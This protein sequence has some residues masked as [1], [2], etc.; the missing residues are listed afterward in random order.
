MTALHNFFTVIPDAPESGQ[1]LGGGSKHRSLAIIVILPWVLLAL[2]AATLDGSDTVVADDQSYAGRNIAQQ[3]AGPVIP[4]DIRDLL[5]EA[6]RLGPAAL[7]QPAAG[8][9]IDPKTG[10][11]TQLRRARD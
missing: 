9:S 8:S 1:G 5:D 11:S 4:V 6:Q 7:D 10:D 3:P 2:A